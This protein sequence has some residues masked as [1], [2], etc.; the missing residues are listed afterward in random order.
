MPGF[1]ALLERAAD[2]PDLRRHALKRLSRLTLDRG[3]RARA[4]ARFEALVDLAP[5]YLVYASDYVTLGTIQLEDGDLD[6]AR[7]TWRRGAAIYPRHHELARLRAQHFGDEAP[8]A[9]PSVPAVAEESLG[10]RRIPVRTP[11]ISPRSDLVTVIG[12]AIAEVC[13][14]G[15]VVAVS[16][17]AVA[18]GQGRL[19]PLELVQPGRLA[20]VLCRFVGEGGPLRSPAGMQGAVLEVGHARITAAAVAGALGKALGRKGWFYVVAGKPAAMID[21]VGAC[22]PPHDHHIIF[23]PRDPDGMA[24]A[25]AAQLGCPVAIVDANHLSGAWVVGASRDVDRAWLAR[26]LSDNPAGNED[27]QTPVVVVRRA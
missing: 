3:D 19:L 15:D 7:E 20:T 21:D 14:P 11:M 24:A 17:S 25:L 27:E 4:R 9:A 16:E 12:E 26:A 13:Q 6:A 22:M 23:G 2:H 18:A 8:V 1:E 10:V 5:D